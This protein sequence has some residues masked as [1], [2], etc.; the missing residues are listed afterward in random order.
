MI[1]DGV[2]QEINAIIVSLYEQVCEMASGA[3][4]TDKDQ[5]EATK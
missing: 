1:P 2:A 5:E 3:F 4:M